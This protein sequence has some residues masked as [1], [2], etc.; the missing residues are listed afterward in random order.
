M[1]I[2]V[3]LLL[4]AAGAILTFA[5]EAEVSGISLET[6]G[7]ILLILGAIGL[8]W[9]MLAASAIGPWHREERVVER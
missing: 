6:V 3:S 8:V 1:G 5:V 7:V 2:G 9:S 4:L